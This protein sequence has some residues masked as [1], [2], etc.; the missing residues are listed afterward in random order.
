MSI[1]QFIGAAPGSTGG[2]VKVTTIAV[3]ILTIAVWHRAGMTASSM[4]TTLS[5]RR[6]TAL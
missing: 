3:V 6:F 2:G 4:T 5:P 1:L